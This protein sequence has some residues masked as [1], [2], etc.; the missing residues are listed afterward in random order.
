M[1]G[2]IRILLVD[3]QPIMRKGLRM[4][5][6]GHKGMDVV[7]EAASVQGALEVCRDSKPDLILLDLSLRDSSGLELIPEVK[8]Q[9]PHI[10]VLVFTMLEE[11]RYLR[12]VLAS[13]GHGYLLKRATETELILAIQA[14]ARGEIYIDSF[15]TRDLLQGV[16][17]EGTEKKETP[18]LSSR[19]K[20]ILKMVALGYTDKQIAEKLFISIKTVESNKARIKEKL[21]IVERSELVQ[22]ALDNYF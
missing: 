14:L 17:R 11:G 5:I 13:G 15:M 19:Q 7:G 2:N 12:K 10:R 9:F 21:N 8:V 4:I 20:E 6:T 18:S 22:Y 1:T 3:D 16:I